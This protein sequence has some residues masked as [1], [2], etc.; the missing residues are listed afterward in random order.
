MFIAPILLLIVLAI[1]FPRFIKFILTL[2]AFGVLFV[3]ASCIDHARAQTITPREGL[4]RCLSDYAQLNAADIIK[5]KAF[6]G[7]PSLALAQMCSGYT[8]TYVF[9]CEQA[10][11]STAVCYAHVKDDAEMA[12]NA[13]SR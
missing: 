1:L 3:V 2:V 7:D 11:N 8:S 5:M 10:G 12:M 4:Q 6:G 9:Q 13:V